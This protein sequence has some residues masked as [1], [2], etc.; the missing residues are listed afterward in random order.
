MVFKEGGEEGETVNSHFRRELSNKTLS[1]VLAELTTGSSGTTFTAELTT[2]S[3]LGS[4]G[5]RLSSSGGRLSSSGSSFGLLL[6]GGLH[7]SIRRATLT[8]KKI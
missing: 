3:G 2:G 4:S 6:F 7:D 8:K 5:S 1:T